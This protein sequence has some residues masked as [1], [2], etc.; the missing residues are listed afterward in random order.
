MRALIEDGDARAKGADPQG[1]VSQV[2][3]SEPYAQNNGVPYLHFRT[4]SLAVRR[5]EWKPSKKEAAG[6]GSLL[7]I[8]QNGHQAWGGWKIHR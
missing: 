1:L 7:P 2:K 3:A 5:V 4:S 6:D 8:C